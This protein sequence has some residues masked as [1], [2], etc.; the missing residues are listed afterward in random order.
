VLYTAYFDEADTHGPSPTI[1]MGG[2]VGTAPQWQIFG[3]RLRGLQ[4][5]D[6]FK[7]VH[8]NEFKAKTGEFSGWSDAKCKKLVEDLTTLVRDHLTEGLTVHLERDRYLSEYRTPPIPKKMNLDSQYGVCF[9]ACMRQV[10]AIVMEDGK[11]H[12]LDVVIEDGHSNVN[13]CV[14][15]CD[16]L[17]RRLRQRRGIDLLGRITVAKKQQA[18]LLMTADFL[19]STYSMMRAS[20]AAGGLDYANEAPEAPKGQAG[21]TFLE[22][23]PDALS[24]LKEDF[25]ADRQEAAAAWRARRQ[26]AKTVRSGGVE[27]GRQEG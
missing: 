17:K 24:R 2:C 6:G 12:R 21:L 20:K 4:R 1:I 22:L 18:P 15:I 3:R 26:A 16:D 10:L 13:D 8:V 9:R 5:R 14:R 19:A 27:A 7:V 25:D 11:N 23:L